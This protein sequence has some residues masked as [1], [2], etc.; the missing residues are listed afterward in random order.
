MSL[1]AILAAP[2]EELAPL[3][4]PPAAFAVLALAIF[5]VLALVSWSYRDVA[6][7]HSHKTE[8]SGPDSHGAHH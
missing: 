7:R 8:G 5:L 3:I 6:N 4:M 1:F 2:A